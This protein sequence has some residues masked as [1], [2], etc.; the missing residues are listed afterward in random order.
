MIDLSAPSTG[1]VIPHFADGGGWTTQ[2]V[3]VNPTSQMIRGTVEFHPN[4]GDV[5]SIPYTIPPRSSFVLRTSSTDTAIRSGFVRV[6]PG[7]DPAPS[8]FVV[9]SFRRNGVTV[10]EASIEAVQP[11]DCPSNL[12]CAYR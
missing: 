5:N 8:A 10:S 2:T 6:F 12:G 7:S 3:L 9:F 1:S 4:S 11:A